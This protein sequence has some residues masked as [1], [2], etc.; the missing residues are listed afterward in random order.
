L[1]PRITQRAGAGVG[2]RAGSELAVELGDQ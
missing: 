2:L 1:S